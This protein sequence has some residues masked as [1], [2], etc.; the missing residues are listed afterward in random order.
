MPPGR[1]TCSLPVRFWLASDVFTMIHLGIWAFM[2]QYD[3]GCGTA[4][5][6][7]W[8]SPPLISLC[9]LF[10]YVSKEASVV[11]EAP[12]LQKREEHCCGDCSTLGES[13]FY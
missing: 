11:A 10:R 2:W 12:A 7:H 9:G 8:T 13:F 4:E 6:T 3:R 1:N 5:L